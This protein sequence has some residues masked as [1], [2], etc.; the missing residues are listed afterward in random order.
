MRGLRV[1]ATPFKSVLF[2]T[3]AAVLPA[4]G[5]L[6]GPQTA[7][8]IPSPAPASPI[9]PTTTK[10]NPLGQAGGVAI[11][12]ADKQGFD[13]QL[14]RYV[15]TGSVRLTFNGWTLLADRLEVDERSRSFYA[16][17]QVRLRKGD[18]YLQA[19]NIRYSYW[20]GS[21]ELEDVY[22]VIDQDTLKADTSISS[23]PGNG[24]AQ[25]PDAPFACPPLR[26]TDKPTATSLIPPGRVKLPVMAAGA[27]C[28]G[29]EPGAR[30]KRML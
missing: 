27:G 20:E 23:D 16:T 22:G 4:V 15:A 24:K 8:P 1:P 30:P 10:P 7:I 14:N 13:G 29:G 6:A 26:A 2:G 25:K 5:A 12:N 17:G 11:I 9:K 3:V 18:Q 19:S 28:P 21:G